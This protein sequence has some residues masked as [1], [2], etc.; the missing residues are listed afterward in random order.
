MRA[1]LPAIAGLVVSGII[2]FCMKL[3]GRRLKVKFT[4]LGTLQGKSFKEIADKVGMPNKVSSMEDGT[5][6]KQWM[7]AEYHISLV[8]DEN[9]ICLSVSHEASV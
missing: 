7:A 2:S 4:K 9:D 3:P 1:V 5:T 6:L 8:F